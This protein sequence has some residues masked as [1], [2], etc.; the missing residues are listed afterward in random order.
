MKVSIITVS[1]NSA[2]TINDTILSVMG[3]TW[4]NV[5]YIIVDGG[6]TDNTLQICKTYGNRIAKIIS[7]P[8]K[9][10]YDAMNKGLALATGDIIGILNSDDVYAY[11][12]VLEDVV[13]KMLESGTNALYADLVYVD[14]L[15]LEKIKRYWR[16]GEFKKNK[17]KWGWM[18]PHP[19]VFFK[20][21]LYLQFGNFNLE[22][23]S[24]AD[25]ELMLRFFYKHGVK[26]AYLPKVITRMRTGGESNAS[27]KNRV[28]AN[29]EDRKAWKVN[30]L[31]PN[32]LTLYLKPLRKI[33]QFI[34]RKPRA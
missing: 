24:A 10:I 31:R 21:D 27:V 16:S 2:K 28:K 8:D 4:A 34:F 20:K 33:P 9:G 15:N 1:Y 7:E 22:F 11:G 25:Y 3:Q 23:R 6:S 13:K 30:D 32:L 14:R 19:T 18:P 17:F 5:E 26:P 29:N 12:T